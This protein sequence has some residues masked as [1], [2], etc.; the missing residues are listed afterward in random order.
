MY[1]W[2]RAICT[3]ALHN[4]LPI[5]GGAN[6][7]VEIGVISLGTTSQGGQQKQVKV[8]VI[9][10]LDTKLKLIR[11]RAIEP[12]TDGDKNYKKRFAKIFEPLATNKWVHPE[13]IILT[14][15]TIDKGTLIAMGYKN[16]I[17]TPGPDG[18][19]QN[20]TIMEYLRTVVPRMFQNT[21]S[22]LS[23]PIIQQFL[24]ELVWREWY[25]V[26]PGKAFENLVQHIA[27]QSLV[28]AEPLVV[29][30]NKV[31]ANPFKNW[32]VQIPKQTLKQIAKNSTASPGSNTNNYSVLKKQSTTSSKHVPPTVQIPTTTESRLR[33]TR[34]KRKELCK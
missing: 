4:H 26:S 30:L 28:N 22:L 29:R 13:S 12:I 27:E 15:L 19:N 5:F 16:I 2:F 33:T 21:L 23:R 1:T 9:G 25:G 32:S 10:I 8:E 20:A 14:D 3:M 6:S 11:L 7:R 17:Q 31:S 34:N 24:D 18:K